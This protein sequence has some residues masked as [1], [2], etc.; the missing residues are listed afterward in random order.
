MDRILGL[1][2]TFTNQQELRTTSSQAGLA[3]FKPARVCFALTLVTSE[4]TDHPGLIALEGA[5]WR[6][7][8]A[9]QIATKATCRRTATL[10]PR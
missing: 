1:R 4:L 7:T 8:E 3:P 5:L 2:D 9:S 10:V 6:T